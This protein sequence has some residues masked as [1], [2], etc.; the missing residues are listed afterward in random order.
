MHAAH[1]APES[2]RSGGTNS[3]ERNPERT[4]PGGNSRRGRMAVEPTSEG[5]TPSY[6]IVKVGR[7]PTPIRSQLQFPLGSAVFLHQ[8]QARV[9]LALRGA[10]AHQCQVG[11]HIR[12]PLVAD[13]TRIR[14]GGRTSFSVPQ[15]VSE[16]ITRSRASWMRSRLGS[17]SW[18]MQ[19][20]GGRCL[21]R[22][23]SRV[24]FSR[25]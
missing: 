19:E 4:V 24:Q 1:G 12:P 11:R 20:L 16:Y 22:R 15:A 18:R 10:W 9:V 8:G 3:G 13:I 25:T 7:P 2:G 17:P 5:S 21:V 14:L 6:T 23:L